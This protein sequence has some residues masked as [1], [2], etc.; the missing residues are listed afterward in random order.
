MNS[1]HIRIW[2]EAIV[3]YFIV[4]SGYDPSDTEENYAESG[5][6]ITRSEFD[7]GTSRK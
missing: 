7:P 3:T 6:Q 2:K 1:E 5:Q 4:P